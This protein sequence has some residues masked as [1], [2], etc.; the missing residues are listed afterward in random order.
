MTELSD[1][2]SKQRES[3]MD[4]WGVKPKVHSSFA[5]SHAAGAASYFPNEKNN[6]ALVTQDYNTSATI[7]TSNMPIDWGV[8]VQHETDLSELL[9]G[10]HNILVAGGVA[11]GVGEFSH[12]T[13]NSWKGENGK[14]YSFESNF[15]GDFQAGSRNKIVEIA[16][17][18]N[19]LGKIITTTDVLIEAS[20]IKSLVKKQEYAKA[21]KV[22]DDAAMA[23]VGSFGGLP[24]FLLFCGYEAIDKSIGWD[25]AAKYIRFGYKR[26]DELQP[27]IIIVNTNPLLI[28]P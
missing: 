10:A 28:G 26:I 7:P 17:R 5:G 13:E 15:K 18:Y 16:K 3:R 25:K 21:A 2:A 19:F 11:A 8:G 20:I 4:R 24:G 1:I 14:W 9:E 6:P 23:I 22:T 12:K 27:E